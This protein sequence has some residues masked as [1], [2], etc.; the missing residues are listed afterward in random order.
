M[1]MIL[2]EIIESALFFII[3]VLAVYVLQYFNIDFNFF[4]VVFGL[5]VMW[6][7]ARVFMRRRK[8]QK[9]HTNN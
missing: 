1:K 2:S 9:M 4:Y 8:S 6:T 7:T 5:L 3:L